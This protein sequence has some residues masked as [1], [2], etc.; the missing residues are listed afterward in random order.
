MHPGTLLGKE[1]ITTRFSKT[2]T[3]FCATDKEAYRTNSQTS[4]N[5]PESTSISL[6]FLANIR[7]CIISFDQQKEKNSTF[8]P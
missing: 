8:I 5:T 6:P 3:T 2:R 4:Y 1:S 7:V